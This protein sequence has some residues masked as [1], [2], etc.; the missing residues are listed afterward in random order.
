MHSKLYFDLPLCFCLWKEGLSVSMIHKTN[1][2]I[3]L[4]YCISF[5]FAIHLL[6]LPF[7][8]C[9][10]FLRV[11]IFTDHFFL[12]KSNNFGVKIFS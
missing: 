1:G 12:F 11:I 9:S 3:H 6:H 7:L 8:F 2:D 4:S 10:K 5:P